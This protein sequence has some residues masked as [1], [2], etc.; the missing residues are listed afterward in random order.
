MDERLTLQDLVA[1]LAERHE[2]EQ[3]DADA[4]VRMMFT[5]I[6]E[7]LRADRY[8]KI[9]GFGTFKLLEVDTRESVDVRTGERIEIQSHNR[10]S[11][12]PDPALRD[13]INKPFAH[14]ET[15]VLNENVRF[16]DMERA[17]IAEKEAE[18]IAET[19]QQPDIKGE[20]INEPSQTPSPEAEQ[21]ETEQ[22]ENILP[23]NPQ[24]NDTY[25]SSQTEKM[26]SPRTP[27]R[28]PYLIGSILLVAIVGIMAVIFLR[29]KDLPQPEPNVQ[30]VAPAD[31]LLVGE[32]AHND[33]P[34]VAVPPVQE[35]QPAAEEKRPVTQT[36]EKRRKETLA[37]TTEYEITGTLAVHVIRTGDTLARLARKFY[38]QTEMWPYIV[39]HNQDIITDANNVPIGTSIRIPRLKRKNL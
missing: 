30:A 21:Q 5:L 39:K 15:V 11:F 9:K 4:F 33:T 28:M 6:E 18:S 1:L 25:R 37:D 22:A 32:A 14:F 31:T 17:D 7:G 19:V 3:A 8:V 10:I 35:P 2:M 20:E 38:G 26:Q 29:R 27:G 36:R 34:V 12:T 23:E 13:F 24:T 16:D